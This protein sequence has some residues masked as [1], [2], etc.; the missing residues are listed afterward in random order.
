MVDHLADAARE[1][2]ADFGVSI[3]PRA[4]SPG[5][6][7]ECEDEGSTGMAVIGYAGA[8]VRGALVMVVPES[9]IRTWMVVAGI[10]DGD[11]CDTLGEFS[12]MVFGRLKERLLPAGISLTATTPTA[13]T[14]AD[15]RL[16]E[17]PCPT[18][19]T[20]FDGPDFS[21]RVRLDASFDADFAPAVA[22]LAWEPKVVEAIDFDALEMGEA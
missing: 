22:P 18:H 1:V 19:C 8:G 11:P 12:N 17:A 2:F 4:E 14:G 16:S 21:L 20:S 3:R 6:G 15:L 10:P 5:P 13:A 9:A 7:A